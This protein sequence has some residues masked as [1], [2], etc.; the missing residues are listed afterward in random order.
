[1]K[2]FIF[3][4]DCGNPVDH[5]AV[6][7]IDDDMDYVYIHTCLNHYQGFFKRLKVAFKYIFCIDNNYVSHT[8]T[9]VKMDEFREQL[10]DI[11][12]YIDKD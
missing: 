7:S 11:K 12:E 10:S 8:D 1:M 2:Q 5:N 3:K 6:V 4:C 9:L